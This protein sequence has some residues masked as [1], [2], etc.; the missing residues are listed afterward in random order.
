MPVYV[1]NENVSIQ[2]L[3]QLNSEANGQGHDVA[4]W[5]S[6]GDS[7]P[8]QISAAVAIIRSKSSDLEEKRAINCVSASI[9]I[10]C[11]YLDDQKTL[12]PLAE[13]FCTSKVSISSGSLADALGGNHAI[14]QSSDGGP[15]EKN[16]QKPHGC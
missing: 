7:L 11:V 15:A 2:E 5:P 4:E 12:S 6:G 14:Q 13:K 16:K 3:D 8:D 1:L 9:P 10:V